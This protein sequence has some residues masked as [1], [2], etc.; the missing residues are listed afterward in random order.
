MIAASDVAAVLGLL[1]SALLAYPAWKGLKDRKTIDDALNVFL[2]EKN[3]ASKI[4]EKEARL[5]ALE[6]AWQTYLTDISG[7]MAEAMG[8]YPQH[9]R[10]TLWGLAALFLAFFAMFFVFSHPPACPTATS[11]SCVLPSDG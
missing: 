6:S 11:G 1:G 10:L 3:E 9:R 7:A 2:D 8:Q 5:A 4:A